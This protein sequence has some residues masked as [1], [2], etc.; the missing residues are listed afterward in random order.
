MDNEKTDWK[1]TLRQAKIYFVS[2]QLE[3][4]IEYFSLAEKGGH[5]LPLI[6]MSRGAAYIVLGDYAAAKD[7]LTLVLELG[8]QKQESL[9]FSWSGNGCLGGI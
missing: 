4:S 5:E 8:S 3:K 7:D 1:K 2:G 6:W 9:L